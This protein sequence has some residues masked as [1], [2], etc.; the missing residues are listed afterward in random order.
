MLQRLLD[1]G[2]DFVRLAHSVAVA[3]VSFGV[4][5]IIR[6]GTDLGAEVDAGFLGRA[7]GRHFGGNAVT[8]ELNA[9]IDIRVVGD[10]E[11][12]SAAAA[13]V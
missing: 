10:N 6:L 7:G 12:A 4:M 13:A 8:S 3:A 9:V 11:M 1:G 5:L 2:F